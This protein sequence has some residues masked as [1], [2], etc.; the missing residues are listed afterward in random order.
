MSE[1]PDNIGL[2]HELWRK[3]LRQ[4]I[5]DRGLGYKE[6]SSSAGFN[7]EYVSKMLNGRINPTVDKILR[8]CEVAGIE[9]SFLFLRDVGG[10]G[11][12]ET[13]KDAANLTEQD[14]SLVAR[15][16]DSARKS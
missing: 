14:A 5:D 12:R 10:Q 3:R 8:I 1:T 4:A 2:D 7:K 6:L 15:L 13:V 11:I 16:I 9:P